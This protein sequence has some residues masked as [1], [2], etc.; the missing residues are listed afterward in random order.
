S[1]GKAQWDNIGTSLSRAIIPFKAQLTMGDTATAGDIFDSVQMRGA[2]LASD[3]EMLPDSQRGFAPIVRGIAK[4]NA[5]V[6][7]E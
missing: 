5:E 7:V 3:E 2:M 4:S 1:G 6:S